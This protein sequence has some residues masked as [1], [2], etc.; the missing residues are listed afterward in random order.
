M[1]KRSRKELVSL[2]V[3]LIGT[4]YTIVHYLVVVLHKMF[5]FYDSFAELKF[6]IE[7]LLIGLMLFIFFEHH[8]KEILSHVMDKIRSMCLKKIVI[9]SIL[10][11]SLI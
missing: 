3:I 11:D 4:I 2:G 8:K 7:K 1:I 6:W 9:W 5:L 10:L